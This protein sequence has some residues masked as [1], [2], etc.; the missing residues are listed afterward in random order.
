[1]DD[2]II[3]FDSLLVLLWNANRPR[4]QKTEF[5]ILL[6]DKRIGESMHNSRMSVSIS[7]SHFTSRSSF[8]FFNYTSYRTDRPKYEA[9]GH[10]TAK[11]VTAVFI[12]KKLRHKLHSGT[13]TNH[14]HAKAIIY[15]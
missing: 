12:E 13:V 14:I 8:S 4:K 5:V 7:E 3:N 2:N 1:M 9:R 10:I 6:H 11:Y 15:I